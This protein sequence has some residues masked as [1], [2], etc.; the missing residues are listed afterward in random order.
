MFIIKGTHFE[1]SFFGFYKDKHCKFCA[2]LAEILPQLLH[3]SES[4]TFFQFGTCLGV[5]ETHNLIT[6]LWSI[7]YKSH[8]I[9]VTLLALKITVHTVQG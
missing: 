3:L 7:F 2:I 6:F 9:N 1:A 5:L 8:V 4:K